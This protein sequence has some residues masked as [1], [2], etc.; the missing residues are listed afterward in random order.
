MGNRVGGKL[1]LGADLS[2]AQPLLYLT[3]KPESVQLSHQNGP[4]RYENGNYISLKQNTLRRN[5]S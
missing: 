4:P 3:L 2:R 5:A 1:I